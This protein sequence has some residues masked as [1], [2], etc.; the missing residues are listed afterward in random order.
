MKKNQFL[1]VGAALL[2]VGT[3]WAANKVFG[4]KGE[5]SIQIEQVGSNLEVRKTEVKYITSYIGDYSKNV[6]LKA[7]TNTK[8]NTGAEGSDGTSVVEARSAKDFF[9]APIWTVAADGQD[10][11]Y[12]N[13]ELIRIVR[14]GCCGD[15][16]RSALYNVDDGQTPATYLDDDFFTISVPNGGLNDRY[17]AQID[18]SQAPKDKNGKTYMGTIAYFDNHQKKG[19]VRF[20]VQ[21]PQGWG[22]QIMDVNLVNT[23]PSSKNSLR[24]KKMDLW[25]SD[26]NKDAKSAFHGFAMTGSIYLENKKLDLK[27][28]VSNDQIDTSGIQVSP[29]LEFEVVL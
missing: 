21:L 2:I 6:L 25:D 9:G 19:L 1:L 27:V 4:N 15:F 12:V 10:V 7:T 23:D 29:D 28:P 8:Y 26:G 24:D 17:M 3:A 18:D 11:S 5:S 20:Y 16:T 14:Y 13:E 22:A